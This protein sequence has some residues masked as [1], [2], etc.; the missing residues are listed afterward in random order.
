[1][2]LEY[3]AKLENLHEI[4]NKIETFAKDAGCA[5]NRLTQLTI[6]AEELIV[7][8]MSYAYTDGKGPLN[9]EIIDNP[10]NITLILS[11]KGVEFNPLDASPPEQVSIIEEMKTGGLGI[12]MVKEFADEISYKRHKGQNFLTVSYLK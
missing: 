9:I 12:H 3:P 7:N 5:E 1:M 11:D 4:L 6:L 10:T 8:I 2:K